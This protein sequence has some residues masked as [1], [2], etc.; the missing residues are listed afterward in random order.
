[1]PGSHSVGSLF[2]NIGGSSKGLKKALGNAKKDLSSFASSIP[3]MGGG[4]VAT[5]RANL[6]RAN[7]RK[8]ALDEYGRR[9]PGRIKG[10]RQQFGKEMART[11]GEQGEAKAELTQATAA[12]QMRFSLAVFG[13]TVGSVAAILKSGLGAGQQSIQ[14]HMQFGAMGPQG[15]KF[16]QSQVE[17]LMDQLAHA[18]SPEGSKILAKQAERDK[19][20]DEVGRKW[21]GVADV[22]NEVMLTVA[23]AFTNGGM[24]FGNTPAA[25][26]AGMRARERQDRVASPNPGVG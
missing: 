7:A 13:V 22:F 26:E 9:G 12:R 17:Q 1:M 6:Q 2:V 4:A 15:A 21:E 16:V 10:S 23:D 20:W 3:G 14:K 11:V 24:R 18:E 25:I 5:A 19:Q 8:A